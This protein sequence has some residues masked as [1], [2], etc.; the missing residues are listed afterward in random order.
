MSFV[1]E[2]F[3]RSGE[4][5]SGRVDASTRE[6]ATEKL[7]REGIFPT[8]V[9]EGDARA[10]KTRGAKGA[11]IF[12]SRLKQKAIFI[13]QLQV[14]ISTGTPL[15]EAL[16]AVERQS[17]DQKWC[18][19]IRDVRERLEEGSSFA[20]ALETH[21]EVFDAVA[22]SLISA[23]ESS[24]Q[25]DAMLDRLAALTKQQHR[26]RSAFIG[27]LIYPALLTLVATF[28]LGLMLLFVLP[29]FS[30]LFE[31]L[32]APLPPTTEILID[33]GVLLRT[34]WWALPIIAAAITGGGWYFLG[35]DNGKRTLD[36]IAVKAPTIGKIGRSL[37]TARLSRMLGVLLQSKVPLLEAL[38]LTGATLS[39]YHFV[40]LVQEAKEAATKGQPI[41][42][43]FAD[44]PL[45]P[46]SL[47][48][49]LRNGEQTGR[50]GP[51]LVNVADFLDEENETLLK[52][53]SST[54]EP[55]ILLALGVIV[56]FV[57][58]SLFLPLFDLTSMTGGH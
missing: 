46:A 3:D 18:D 40:E 19:V 23:G 39:N 42:A 13:R 22:R 36:D 29:R 52:S 45:V 9:H 20:E 53:L 34:Y 25:L 56:G 38:D 48:E 33:L 58:L 26:T 14:M 5:R 41:S 6:E 28:V 16:G 12:G 30:G 4:K 43:A 21:P 57:A 31:T 8:S 47:T 54:L 24:G 11:S 49:A 15:V 37:A 1:Y 10:Q 55:I 2:G 27:A 51:V 17:K 35:T 44:C 32:D 7:R 50:I